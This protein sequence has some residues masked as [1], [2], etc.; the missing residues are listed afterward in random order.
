MPAADNK[1]STKYVFFLIILI[2]MIFTY[3]NVMGKC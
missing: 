2:I 1:A 3:L